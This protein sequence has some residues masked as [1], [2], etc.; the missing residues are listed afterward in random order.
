MFVDKKVKEEAK[1][2]L[3]TVDQD[4]NQAAREALTTITFYSPSGKEYTRVG[5]RTASDDI[6]FTALERT[7]GNVTSGTFWFCY[8][9]SRGESRIVALATGFVRTGYIKDLDK[10][11]ISY[12]AYAQDSAAKG[13][14][15]AYFRQYMPEKKLKAKGMDYDF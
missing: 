9:E 4:F 2:K 15:E 5:L 6:Y 10:H 7:E 3:V 8:A 12:E 14:L 11:F 1:A 13:K